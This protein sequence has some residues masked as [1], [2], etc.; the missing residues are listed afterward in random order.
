MAKRSRLAELLK[1]RARVVLV[2]QP[3]TAKRRLNFQR[4]IDS[5]LKKLKMPLYELLPEDVTKPALLMLWGRDNAEMDYQDAERG[6]RYRQICEDMSRLD[7]G[8]IVIDRAH[9]LSGS[10]IQLLAQLVR[11]VQKATLDWQFIL[12]ADHKHAN[13]NRLLSIGVEHF[14][15]KE[16]DP[17]YEGGKG[18]SEKESEINAPVKDRIR[19]ISIGLACGAALLAV[20]VLGYY[21]T[22][23]DEQPLTSNVT[24]VQEPA[25]E[26]NTSRDDL[27]GSEQSL[28]DDLDDYLAALAAKE[29]SFEEDMLRLK[30]SVAPRQPGVAVKSTAVHSQGVQNSEQRHESRKVTTGSVNKTIARKKLTPSTRSLP[31]EVLRAIT[32]GDVGEIN[33]LS[34]SGETFSG[35]GKNG[36]SAL[37]AGV[38]ANK[39]EVIEALT[40]IGVQTELVDNYGRTAL[41]YS[42]IQGN[43]SMV[44]L[45][46]EAGANINARTNLDKTPLMA[47]VHNGHE[48]VTQYLLDSGASP[49]LQDHSGWSALFYAAWNGRS[50]LATLLKQRG[51]QESLRDKDGYTLAEISKIRSA[52]IN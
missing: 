26:R 21:L 50:D 45:L 3:I 48:A 2:K 24:V 37:V 29:K 19:K 31:D 14:Y 40:D 33:S 15:P 42:A 13:F 35:R 36:E 4:K 32:S 7:E 23:D 52:N 34:A 11:Y 8:L 28:N 6:T 51:A 16:L 41:Y 9:E 1:S 47:A 39:P 5:A 44:K 43:V 17:G 18:Y 12:L 20:V 25:E 38:M 22:K 49:D 10:S 30:T 46:V 27:G